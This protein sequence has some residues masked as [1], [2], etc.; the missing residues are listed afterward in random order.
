[1]KGTKKSLFYLTRLFMIGEDETLSNP[2]S[3]NQAIWITQG[4]PEG[5]DELQSKIKKW[6]SPL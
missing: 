4:V 3:I 1:M 6:V 2:K 5:A